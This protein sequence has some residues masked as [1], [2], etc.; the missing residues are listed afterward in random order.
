METFS[1]KCGLAPRITCNTPFEQLPVW[2]TPEEVGI[3]TSRTAQ[4]I[5]QS[6]AAGAGDF[7]G[8]KIGG[9]WYIHR[10]YFE[11]PK[12]E[13]HFGRRKPVATAS[14]RGGKE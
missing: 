9:R 3:Y 1:K 6:L 4:S 8:R 13:R 11:E 12:I 5:R 7:T 2:L 10:K 14:R